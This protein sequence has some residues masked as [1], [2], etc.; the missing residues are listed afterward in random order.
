ML[1]PLRLTLGVACAGSERKQQA[2]S[3]GITYAVEWQVLTMLS[4][5][6]APQ[7]ATVSLQAT[8]SQLAAQ[9]PRARAAADAHPKPISRPCLL[10]HRQPRSAAEGIRAAGT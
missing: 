9:R 4:P 1:I 5:A 10:D 6:A 8:H 2:D 3:D 7:P